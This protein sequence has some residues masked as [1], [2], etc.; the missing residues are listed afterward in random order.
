MKNPLSLRGM[1][2]VSYWADDVIA[3]RN[4]YNEVFGIE[5]YFHMPN[6]DSP[7]YI[8]YRVGDY[9]NEVGII[10]RKFQP[11]LAQPGPGGAVLYWHVDD[12]QAT[13]DRLIA[14]GATPYQPVTDH[15]GGKNTFVTAS[16]VDPFGN[17]L[18]VMFNQHY[19]DIF[20]QVKP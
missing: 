13:L 14:L 16:V 17:V 5:P 12:L 9:K 2:N 4:W 7:A 20:D 6:A 10:S 15:S 11:E 18:G 19:L 1:A 3:A 8:E